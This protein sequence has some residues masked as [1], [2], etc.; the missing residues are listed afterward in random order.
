MDSALRRTLA[1]VPITYESGLQEERALY[2]TLQVL[3][4]ETGWLFVDNRRALQAYPGPNRLFNNFDYQ[5]LPA[6]SE[7]IGRAQAEVFLQW[8]SRARGARSQR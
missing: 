1:R 8:R 7:I 3:A 4:R 6:A 2:D 5:F